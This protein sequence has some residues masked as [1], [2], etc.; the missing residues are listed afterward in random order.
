MGSSAS[1]VFFTMRLLMTG[2]GVV[3]DLAAGRLNGGRGVGRLAETVE[4]VIRE[5]VRTRYL[6]RQKLSLAV[7]YRDIAR[8]CTRQ[9]LPVPARNTVT[10]RIAWMHPGPSCAEQGRGRCRPCLAGSGGRGARDFGSAGKVQVDHTVIDLIIVDER[11]RQ[12]IGHVRSRGMVLTPENDSD[13]PARAG[14]GH[15]SGGAAA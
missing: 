7:V 3:T 12:P 5:A 2:S 1:I 15:D 4:S 13:M 11:D 6:K 9:G 8:A 10:A 14:R